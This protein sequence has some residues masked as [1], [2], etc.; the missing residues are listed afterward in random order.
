VQLAPVLKKGI[1][2]EAAYKLCQDAAM[3]TIAVANNLDP[4]RARHSVC[5]VAWL[6]KFGAHGVTRLILAPCA[7]VKLIRYREV[8]HVGRNDANFV[9]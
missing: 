1:M 9:E 8:K 3:K 5:A 7:N 4:G 6:A 2:R